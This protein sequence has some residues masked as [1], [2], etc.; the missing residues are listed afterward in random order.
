MCVRVCVHVSVSGLSIYAIHSEGF[1]EVDSN[2]KT[3]HF[4]SMMFFKIGF[5]YI[6]D[7]R[8]LRH[9]CFINVHIF[10]TGQIK[11]SSVFAYGKLKTHKEK[12]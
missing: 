3:R 8:G 6:I 11:F 7:S 9:Y 10:T 5:I 2:R 1:K 12:G 4:Q